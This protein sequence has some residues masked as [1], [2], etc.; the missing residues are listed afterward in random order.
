MTSLTQD[1]I[2][3]PPFLSHADENPPF[4]LL[5]MHP[6]QSPAGQSYRLPSEEG[7]LSLPP[8]TSVQGNHK[9]EKVLPPFSFQFN[10]LVYWE[11]EQAFTCR[12]N[13]MKPQ[14]VPSFVEDGES[15]C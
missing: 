2:H 8:C 6:S 13:E 5:A 7:V 15:Q 3:L 10:P 1:R 11:R 14:A 12:R 9:E 4:I